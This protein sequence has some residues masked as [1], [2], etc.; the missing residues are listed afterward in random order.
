MDGTQLDEDKIIQI[1]SAELA[2]AGD[3]S[4][5]DSLAVGN[6]RALDYYM[7]NL[8]APAPEGRS[9]VVSTD[10][11][12]A[13]EW[14]LPQIIKA[15][16]SKGPI[17]TFDALE[18]ADEEQATIETE[19]VH[20]VFMTENPGFLNLYEFVKD[21]LLQKNGIFKVYYDDTPDITTEQYSGVFEPQIEQ[22]VW[23]DDVEVTNIVPDGELP[24]TPEQVQQYEQQMQ[25]F[26]QQA[27]QYQQQMKQQKQP[28]SEEE[29]EEEGAQQPPQQPQQPQPP[30]ATPT[31]SV[32]ISRTRSR[33][34]GKVVP[35]PIEEFRISEFHDSPNPATANFTAHVMLKTRS[36]LIQEGYDR[37]VIDDAPVGADD[38]D[39]E[40]RWDAQGEDGGTAG[41]TISEDR[42]QD[43]IEVSECFMQMDIN[44]DGISEMVKVTVLGSEGSVKLLN[45]EEIEESPFV[46]SS[47]II[48]PH[49]FRGLSIFDRLHTVQDQKTSLWRNIL[50]NLYLQNNREKEVVEDQVNI[51]DLLISRPGGIKRVKQPGMIRELQV[52]PIGQEGYQMMQYLDT[53]RMGRVG[54][55]PDTMGASLP[56]GGDTAHGVERMMS[57]KEEMTALMIR[58]V[59][60]TGLKAAY[61]LIRNLL[62]RHMDSEQSFKYRGA[63]AKVRPGSW[64]PRSKTSVNVGTGSGDDMR[65]Q[66]ALREVLQYQTTLAGAGLS[67]LINEERGFNALDSFCKATGLSGG[68]LYFVDPKSP[69]GVRAAEKA[70]KEA[71]EAKAKQDEMEKAITQAQ[72][73]LAQAEVMK[74]QAALQSQKVKAESE[75]I[76]AESARVE[77][78]MQSQL[79]ML[80]QQLNEAKALLEKGKDDAQLTLDTEKM[81]QD[82]NVKMTKLETDMEIAML[83]LDME[84]MKLAASVKAQNEQLAL[85]KAAAAQQPKESDSE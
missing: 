8:P 82:T 71:G 37:D 18:E 9:D 40:Y 76:K 80:E 22:L 44:D 45:V 48:M 77:L 70:A 2:A 64:G 65:K 31:Y 57:A 41:E 5:A 85:S 83:N 39:R 27:A 20:S 35:V 24:P 1:V 47:C 3:G 53:V 49:K 6:E 23:G 14:I 59:A 56:V 78:E 42:S 21:A 54:V 69:E 33:G 66:A 28:G 55:S 84:R 79:S 25:Q 62:I 52:Q 13:I 74:G 75:R 60:E 15:L 73:Q 51:D 4:T 63:W 16:I 26:K 58:S 29:E 67:T 10:V 34:A 72:Q 30:Q 81:N 32:T 36:E 61:V 43:L 12:D 7:G 38:T 19:Y 50:D 46:S 68:D 11:A 17:I